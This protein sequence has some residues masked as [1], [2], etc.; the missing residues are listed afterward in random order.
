MKTLEQHIDDGT[1]IRNAWT[2]TDDQGRKTACLLAALAPETG[3]ARSASVC[4]ATVMPLWLAHLTVW[5]D[6]SGSEAAWPA[7]VRRYAGLASRWHALSP[8]DWRRL[9]YRVRVICLDEADRHYDHDLYPAVARA[10]QR[11]RAL[12]CRAGAGD[13]PARGEW[14]ADPAAARET[15][16]EEWAADP[17]AAA[18]CA[19][20]A[21]AACA[22][23]SEAAAASWEAL[24]DAAWVRAASW[25]AADRMTAALLDAIEEVLS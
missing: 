25:A 11:V 2:G 8:E 15:A 4:P 5:I 19:G 14:A 3:R 20:A 18:S 1:L 12:C 24:W 16:R 22:G 6:D 13:M 7:M 17:A 23:A 9:D 10:V 21:E